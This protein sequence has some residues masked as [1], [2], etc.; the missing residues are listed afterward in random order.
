MLRK[1]TWDTSKDENRHNYSPS[2]R[3]FSA[4]GS[5]L[6][7]VI[8]SRVIASVVALATC[9][10]SGPVAADTLTINPDLPFSHAFHVQG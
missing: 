6:V 10:I 3:G 8:G 4:V 5:A 1:V 7:L 2:L 9:S